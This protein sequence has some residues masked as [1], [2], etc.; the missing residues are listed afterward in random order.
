MTASLPD[1]VIAVQAP[2]YPVSPTQFAT[3]SAFAEHLKELRTSVG[4]GF[5]RV[6]L[7]APQLPQAQYEA[8]KQHLGSIDLARD[9]IV[10]L[11]THPTDVSAKNF[12]LKH[13][14]RIWQQARSAARTAGIVHSGLADDTYRPMLGF[15]NLAAWLARRPVIFVVDIDFR[16]HTRRYHALGLWSRKS[17]LVN[18]VL[19]DPF[20][21]V[22]VW[23]ATRQFQ[24]VLLK[25]ASMVKDFGA[26]R[27]NVKNFYDTVHAAKDVLSPNEAVPRLAWLAEPHEPL[28]LAYFGRFVAY[29]GLDRAIEGVRLARERG[30]NVRLTLIGEGECRAALLRQV[31]TGGL[32][33]VVTFLPPVPYGPALFDQLA[34]A[35]LTIATP[36]TEDTPRAAFDSMARGLPLLAFDISYFK[37][38][39]D[40][41]G[42]VV[43]ARWH[44]AASIADRLVELARNRSPLPEMARR[45]LDFARANTQTIWL[46]RRAGW[47]RELVQP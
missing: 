21:W 2:A 1:Y 22:Q 19:H 31:E 45:G 11:P 26:G 13:A 30:A 24:L 40:E 28:H 32:A 44:E 34:R 14:R 8:K 42:A 15:V 41:S 38:L 29:K 6:V 23:L 47:V 10:F 27:P 9:G 39:A 35:H 43:L 36:L 3:E 12:W 18:R 33:D 25:S 4:P 17:Y 7:I 46:E 37:D 16:Q 5:G 20:K